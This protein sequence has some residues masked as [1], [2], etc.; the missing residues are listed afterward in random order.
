M[1]RRKDFFFG[2]TVRSA[3]RPFF[4]VRSGRASV[5][6]HL[7]G[8]TVALGIHFDRHRKRILRPESGTKDQLYGGGP[9]F[10]CVPDVFRRYQDAG[11]GFLVR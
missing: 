7:R 3:P 5:Q 9:D 10:L 2:K 6:P 8:A 4:V 11:G 1:Y